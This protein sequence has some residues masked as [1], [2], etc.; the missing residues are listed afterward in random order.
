MSKPEKK[1]ISQDEVQKA[2]QRFQKE[3]GLITQLPDQIVPP[4]TRVGG[5]FAAYESVTDTGESARS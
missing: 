3:G 2:L 4:R 1:T 5:K